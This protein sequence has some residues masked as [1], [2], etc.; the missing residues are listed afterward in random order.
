[1]S[2]TADFAGIGICSGI[3]AACA[4]ASYVMETWWVP[5]SHVY[6]H[7]AD[8]HPWLKHDRLLNAPRMSP[9]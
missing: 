7:C 9:T 5:L 2:Y 4:I 6:P 1:M 3:S 8:L